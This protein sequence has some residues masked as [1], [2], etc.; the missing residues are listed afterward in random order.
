MTTLLQTAPYVTLTK[1]A[2][3]SHYAPVIVS[4]AGRRNAP[5]HVRRH[6]VRNVLSVAMTYAQAKGMAFRLEPELAD[7]TSE[8]R[9]VQTELAERYGV[10]VEVVL[11]HECRHCGSIDTY[12]D[13][14]SIWHCRACRGVF[15][16]PDMPQDFAEGLADVAAGARY[17]STGIDWEAVENEPWG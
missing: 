11:G 12:L 14:M 15:G 10:S 5:I 1:S 6:T 17:V 4:T 8:A 2:A 16:A 13:P 9:A 7:L 3:G